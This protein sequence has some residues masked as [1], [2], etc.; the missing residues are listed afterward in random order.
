[1]SS[2]DPEPP[3]AEAQGPEAAGAGRGTGPRRLGAWV[4]L[5][6]LL[7][8]I[9]DAVRAS[10]HLDDFHSLFHARAADWREFLERVAQDNHPPL[11]FALLRVVRTTV[12]EHEL[13]LR[14][15]NVAIG[16]VAVALTWRIG[17]RLGHE[18][19]RLFAA[20]LVACSTL[21]LDLSTDL[22]MYALLALCVLGVLDA[23]L[24]VLD[25]RGDG[26]V[27]GLPAALRLPVWTAL[28]LLSHYHALHAGVA[29]GV[30]LG[31]TAA[32][33]SAPRAEIRRTILLGAVG[34]LLAS[35]WYA[36]VFRT[37]LEHELAPGG[38][39]ISLPILG[40]SFVHLLF[41]RLELFELVRLPLLTLGL[42]AFPL[43]WLG[44]G[45][46]FG[47]RS[48]RGPSETPRP[49]RTFAILVGSLAF[50]L[51]VWT[52]GVAWLQPRA[53]FE[54]RYL[55]SAIAPYC[56]LLGAAAAPGRL[57]GLRRGLLVATVAGAFLLALGHLRDPG[58]EDYRGATRHVLERLEPG[59][60]LLG[61]EWQP[62]LFP[63]GGG[64]RTYVDLLA[65][66]EGVGDPAP[67][68]VWLDH[69]PEFTLTEPARLGE[70]DAVHCLLRSIPD[71]VPLLQHLRREFPV[72]E[73]QRFGE[74]VW[75]L[76]FRRQDP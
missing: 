12:G 37:Q 62:R 27:L 40:E 66:S 3:H 30:G 34:F 46:A 75:V 61:V 2:A 52:A 73:K 49:G 50:A 58:R 5:L 65:S 42:V 60:G 68:P 29:L 10:F 63:R 23:V 45:L 47:G 26:R 17:R 31:L 4:V 6:A 67:Q 36:T 19:G 48:E 71:D 64:L 55:A 14:L 53:G 13:W 20:L 32:L 38:S 18:A 11:S 72:E 24:D 59:D 25:P 56:L 44:L 1:M 70:L 22:R 28:A 69:T 9:G 74:A 41:V 33:R 43:A 15:P 35:P 16:T 21:H 39:A 54:W 8:R 57:L 7:L 76:T 51:P